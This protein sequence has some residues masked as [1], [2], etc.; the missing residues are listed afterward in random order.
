ML[1]I[2]W[3]VLIDFNIPEGK[4]FYFPS[5]TEGDQGRKCQFSLIFLY[6]GRL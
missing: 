5:S 4:Q 3:G 2:F 1:M 6:K